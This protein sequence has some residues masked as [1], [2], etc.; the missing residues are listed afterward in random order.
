[1]QLVVMHQVCVVCVF[2]VRGEGE[3]V[4]FGAMS[5]T[6]AC[7]AWGALHGKGVRAATLLPTNILPGPN[8]AVSA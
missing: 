4:S 2:W 7:A 1:M 5:M 3:Q 6:P 8:P